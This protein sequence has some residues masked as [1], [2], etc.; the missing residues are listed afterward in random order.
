MQTAE[1]AV[2]SK[3]T[4]KNDDAAEKPI[5][6][7]IQGDDPQKIEQIDGE[8]KEEVTEKKMADKESQKIIQELQK[9]LLEKEK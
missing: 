9:M 7:Q 3:K 4:K 1:A 6:D 8:L 2:S 5:E